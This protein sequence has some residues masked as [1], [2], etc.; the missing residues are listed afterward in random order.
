MVNLLNEITMKKLLLLIFTASLGFAIQA[1]TV[2]IKIEAGAVVTIGVGSSL[3]VGTAASSGA[4]TNTSSTRFIIESTSAGSGSLITGG[5]PNATVQRY[6]ADNAR[7]MVTPVT[8]AS[9]AND[10]YINVDDDS[11]LTFHTESSNAWDYITDLSTLLTRGTGYSYWIEDGVG[12]NT[13]EFTG[14]LIGSSQTPAITYGGSGKGWNLLGNP[15]PTPIDWDQGTWV[16]SDLNSS[17][18]YIWDEGTATYKTWNGSTGTM[19]NGIIPLGQGFFVEAKNAGNITIPADAR[20]VST[21]VLYKS[22]DNDITNYVRIDLNNGLYGNT[23]FVGFPDLGS[24]EFDFYGDATK[25]YSSMDETQMF[26]IE[27][28]TKLCI[29]ANTPLT[30]GE[31]KTVP[32]H[33]DQVVNGDYSLD[34]SELD[35]LPNMAITLED[36]KTGHAQDFREERV[37][38][39]SASSNDEANRFLLHFAWSPDG[40]G[41]DM[42]PD[43]NI[44]IY[45]Y[46]KDV[47]IRSEVYNQGEIT[48]YDMFGRTIYKNKYHNNHEKIRLDIN[49][50]FVVVRVVTQQGV[51]SEKVY[52]K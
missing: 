36:L 43:S 24:D 11:W 9:T 21:Q 20:L 3:S 26:A 17:T 41:E 47:Y 13:V 7:H 38:N 6:V 44:D 31:S 14:T 28:D 4:I 50:S 52:I 19:G 15:F 42:E 25:L 27:N 1:Q 10:F 34:I 33:M 46:E 48:V 35:Q 8:N 2:G 32:L 37:Y 16:R 40:I 29:N 39:F 5:T 49:N 45:S 12:S 18:V 22:V 23:I 51:K 30:G